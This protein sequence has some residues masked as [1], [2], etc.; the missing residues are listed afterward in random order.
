[1][2]SSFRL[3]LWTIVV[4]V[5]LLPV[6]SGASLVATYAFNNSLTATQGGAPALTAVDPDSA[7]G[8]TISTVYGSTRSVY[9]WTAGNASAA[10][11]AGL[12]FNA[13]FLPALNDYSIQLVMEFTENDADWRRILDVQD[14]A[15]DTG[16]Y[17]DDTNAL[18]LAGPGVSLAKGTHTLSLNTF[19]DIV[20]VDSGGIVS[21]Y[22]DGS[23][24]F[25]VASN[26][27]DVNN[28]GNLI[29]LFLDNNQGGAQ[30][31]YANGQIALFN[32][33]SGGLT[34]QEVATLDQN[35][36]PEPSSWL[37]VAGG[38]GLLLT[39][40]RAFLSRCQ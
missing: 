21:A 2:K 25:S 13:S 1:V 19:Y 24:E 37:L 40:R 10:D 39:G 27:M 11:Q 7:S 30:N 36:V 3:P 9:Q 16:F 5:T 18:D 20:L 26:L 12:S 29:N 14:R 15:S 4:G 38:L 28:S 32:V 31:E 8:F 22:L 17:L 6:A 23:L 33:W 34:A 35:T